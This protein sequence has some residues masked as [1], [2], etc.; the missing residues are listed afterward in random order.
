[1]QHHTAITVRSLVDVFACTQGGDDDG[2]LVFHT[3]GHVVFQAVIA[4]VNNLID[5]K[6]C[7]WLIG[8]GFVVS[9]QGFGDFNQPLFQLLS[10]SCIQSWHGA[11]HTRFALLD[12]QLGIADDE[13]R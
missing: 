10:R 2:H 1:M 5:G 13:Q 6:R 12:D 8:V 3:Q 7:R 4:L 11:H 9:G